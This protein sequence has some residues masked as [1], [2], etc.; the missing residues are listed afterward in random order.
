MKVKGI[1]GCM[2]PKPEHSIINVEKAADSHG[3]RLVAQ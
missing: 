3:C 1:Y 2:L